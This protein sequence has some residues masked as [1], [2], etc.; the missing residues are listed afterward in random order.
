ME[1]NIED[2]LKYYIGQKIHT[3]DGIGT[4][5][6]LPW[7]IA[8]EDRVRVHF[9][10]CRPTPNSIDGGYNKVRNHGEYALEEKSYVAIN[11]PKNSKPDFTV[12]GG[13]KPI[14]RPLSSMTEE[15]MFKVA[16]MEGYKVD[17]VIPNYEDD[18]SDL[19]LKNKILK[20]DF[21]PKGIMNP[22][23]V[24]GTI[25]EDCIG[26]LTS[27]YYG[28]K[29]GEEIWGEPTWDTFWNWNSAYTKETFHFLLSRGFD[30]FGLIESGLAIAETEITSPNT[31]TP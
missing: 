16:E 29:G 3:P 20:A 25:E 22:Q 7:T 1:K 11:A 26:F 24:F 17:T 23:E 31:P 9:G 18:G 19:T 27:S 30:L 4:L 15:E 13:V 14:L 10:K 21:F 28:S 12:P 6:G 2:Y 5:V 8:G